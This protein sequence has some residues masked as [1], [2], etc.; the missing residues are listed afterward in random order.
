MHHRQAAARAERRAFDV[1]HLRCG[2][3]HLPCR[4]RGRRVA[5]AH[6]QTADLAGGAQVTFHQR[7][8]NR[9]RV[10]DVVE[11][12]A[13]RVGGQELVDV[14]V[15]RQQVLHRAGVLGAIQALRRAPARIRVER[16]RAIEPRLEGVDERVDLGRLRALR[17]NRRHH[18][19]AQAADHPLDRIGV[20]G[21]RRGI[22]TL[23]RQAAGAILVAIVVTADAGTCLTSAFWSAGRHGSGRVTMRGGRRDT[24]WL[25]THHSDRARLGR[26]GGSRGLL[27]SRDQTDRGGDECDGDC[28]E[29]AFHHRFCI[30]QSVFNPC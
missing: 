25:T 27:P 15:D 16:G 10:G 12:V 23:E 11:P 4:R 26:G 14:D 30:T 20:I 17:A 5:V 6:R 7:R 3:R 1:P 24:A 18:P 19:G 29:R 8:R 21:C 13:E 28:G 9:L 2:A 22:E